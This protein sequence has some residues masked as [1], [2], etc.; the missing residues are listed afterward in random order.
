MLD[1]SSSAPPSLISTPGSGWWKPAS[2]LIS[3]DLPQPFWPTSAWISPA[4]RSKSTLLSALVETKV[5]DRPR[6]VS[7]GSADP[8]PSGPA[9]G[10]P[11]QLTG[12][13]ACSR[14]ARSLRTTG[15]LA[16][17]TAMISDTPWNIGW[18]QTEADEAERARPWMPKASAK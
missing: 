18:L 5:L 1:R 12:S 14:E 11:C 16:T 9:G 17:A 13:G 8:T 10:A 3:V 15:R 6:T 2:T 7:T 4:R